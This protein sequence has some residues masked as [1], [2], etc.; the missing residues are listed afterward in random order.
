[1]TGNLW[2]DWAL[3]AVSLF[4]TILLLWLGLTVLLNVERR[5]LGVWL[6]GIGLLLGAAFFISH[7][8]IL[9]HDTVFTPRG[10]NFWWQIGWIPVI[11]SPF[12]WYILILWYGGFWSEQGEPIRKRHTIWLIQL[13]LLGGALALLMIF[14]HSLPS[15]SQITVLDLSSTLVI[16]GIPVIFAL[17]PGFIILCIG[18]S[19]DALRHPAPPS[20]LMGTQARE[21]TR[22]WLIGTAVILLLVGLLVA[23]FVAWVVRSAR[24]LTNGV[25]PA[26]LMLSAIWFDLAI[27]ILIATAVVMLGQ[28]L[29]SYEVFTGK[30]LP[31]RGFFRHWRSTVILAFGYALII[32]WSLAFR[33]RPIYSLLLT[34][35]LMATFYALFSWRSFEEREEFMARLRPFVGSQDFVQNLMR[36]EGDASGSAKA[37][38]QALCRDVLNTSQA[39]LIP[40]GSLAAL[41]GKPLTIPENTPLSTFAVD[42]SDFFAIDIMQLGDQDWPYRWALPLWT[43]RGPIGAMLLGDKQDQSLYTQEEIEIARSSAERILDLLTGEEMARRLI[44]TQRRRLA[45]TQVMDRRTRRALHDEILPDLHTAVLRLSALPQDASAP[46]DGIAMLSQIHHQISNLIRSSPAIAQVDA[47]SDFIQALK[48]AVAAEFTDEFESIVWNVQGNFPTLEPVAAEVL[49]HA[50]REAVRNAAVHGRGIHRE[51][52]LSV[53]ISISAD[54]MICIRITDTGVGVPDSELV[55]SSEGGLALHT[56]MIAIIGGTLHVTRHAAGGTEVIITAP[57]LTS[58]PNI[59]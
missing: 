42:G 45:E 34:T 53:V 52:G 29:V 39:Q 48:D 35:A 41:A 24:D 17:F 6:M 50:S 13:S 11:G 27:E 58:N 5:S 28:G 30:V 15:F 57:R 43:E 54:E 1:M 46:S 49:F 36:P 40:L 14:T 22:P 51:H 47:S 23:I 56:T 55:E 32:G 9:G 21:R 26:A 20:R 4:N 59:S 31:R 44:L 25:I 16:G 19:L 38:F 37:V 3:L 33:L 10:L 2:L 18:L 12:A 7:T 8:A